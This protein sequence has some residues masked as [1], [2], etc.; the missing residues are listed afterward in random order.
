[1]RRTRYDL[2]MQRVIHRSLIITLEI[3][4]SGVGKCTAEQATAAIVSAWLYAIG[5]RIITTPSLPTYQISMRQV[6]L[7][8]GAQVQILV[9]WFVLQSHRQEIGNFEPHHHEHQ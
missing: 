2:D 6:P 5:Q 4:P 8:Q 1:M 3:V 7:E 9:C